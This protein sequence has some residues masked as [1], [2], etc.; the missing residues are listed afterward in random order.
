MLSS[1]VSAAAPALW[2]WLIK[3]LEGQHAFLLQKAAFTWPGSLA[4]T[5]ET[6]RSTRDLHSR[7]GPGCLSEMQSKGSAEGLGSLAGASWRGRAGDAGALCCCH[8]QGIDIGTALM[9]AAG[10]V[11]T[12][13]L[14]LCLPGEEQ[15][16]LLPSP[17]APGPS[18]QSMGSSCQP[19]GASQDGVGPQGSPC[20][21]QGSPWCWQRRSSSRA[22]LADGT[23]PALLAAPPHIQALGL[24]SIRVS[25]GREFPLPS[26]ASPDSLSQR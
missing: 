22:G 12:E 26:E 8:S 3:Q 10:F 13:R 19:T 5:G 15:L 7:T 23:A 25:H 1:G 4:S 11:P 17:G 2:R 21:A 16:V 6:W 24:G 20:R 9:A 18:H 14:P